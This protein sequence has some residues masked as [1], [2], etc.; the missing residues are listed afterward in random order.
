MAKS[1]PKSSFGPLHSDSIRRAN[2][3][4]DA[5]KGYSNNNLGYS[6]PPL[7]YKPKDTSAG[8]KGTK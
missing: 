5:A 3:V 1:T 6:G 2:R 8:A 7:L 4:P